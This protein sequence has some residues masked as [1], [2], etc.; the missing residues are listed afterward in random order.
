[1][2]WVIYQAPDHM[3]HATLPPNIL[4]TAPNI[5]NARQGCYLSGIPNCLLMCRIPEIFSHQVY[6]AFLTCN[7]LWRVSTGCP[8]S[9]FSPIS[10]HF[11]ALLFYG[12]CKLPCRLNSIVAMTTGNMFNNIFF[13]K[14]NK[15]VPKSYHFCRHV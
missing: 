10:S 13:S 12:K 11:R 7:W 15:M 14:Q 4:T 9:S 2:L 1:M 5:T 3:H 8:I 6:F